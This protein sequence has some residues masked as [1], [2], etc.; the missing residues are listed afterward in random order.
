MSEVPLR[1]CGSWLSGGTPDTANL[2]YWGGEIPWITASSLKGRYLTGSER[3][4]TEAGVEAGSRLVPKDTILF[5]VR[6]MSLKKEF[7]VGMAVRPVA[8]GQDCKALVPGEGID[9][10]Y[11][12]FALETAEDRVLRM[13]DE[14]SHGTGRLQSSLLADLKVSLPPLA[15]QRRIVEILDTVDE[16]LQATE[17]VIIKYKRLRAGLVT[18]LLTDGSEAAVPMK[19]NSDQRCASDPRQDQQQVGVSNRLTF[20]LLDLTDSMVDG[21]FGSDLKTDHYVQDAGVRVVRLANLGEGRYLNEDE[22]FIEED[23]A[24]LLSRHAVH[25]GD[26]LVAS[27]GDDNHRPGRACLYPAE[28]APGIVKADC[29]RIRPSGLVDPG[30]L[31]EMLNSRSVTSQISRLAQ[32]VTRDR[33]NLG[34]LRWVILQ[35]PPL[36]EQRQIAEILDMID[37]TV[38]ANE[39]KLNKLR[40]FRLGLAADL[41]SG[42]VRLAA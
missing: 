23:H 39:K 41:L 31:M 15:D 34:Q 13:V 33:V 16:T 21:P 11:L 32:G 27:L 4:L 19:W 28:L 25:S 18:D 29:F 3:Q 14:T 9:P 40:A 20:R 42:R 26:V 7:R 35:V 6:G 24:T 12:L 2:T 38:Q 30:F 8:F 36:E 5:V 17:R 1:D 10:K 22:A 37:K